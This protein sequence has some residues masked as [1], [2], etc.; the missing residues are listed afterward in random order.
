[1]PLGQ[2][3][4]WNSV[5]KHALLLLGSVLM[6]YPLLWMLS[7]SFKPEDIIFSEMGLWPRVVT[8][9]NYVKGWTAIGVPFSRLF[10]NS[11]IVSSLAVAGNVTSCA[12]AAY[13]FA[14]LNFK[15][16]NVW[17]M[18]MLVTMMLPLQVTL[19]PRYVMFFKAGWLNTFL[20]LT[21]PNFLAVD[22]FFIFLIV[23]FIRGL[24]H[25][26]D[27]AASIDG[28]SEFQTFLRVI[29]PLAAP[30]LAT[31]AI[32]TFIWSWDN[33]MS[34]LLYLSKV[35]LYTV[36]LGLRA[37]LDA[38]DKS[39]YGSLFAMSV[40]SLIP[41]FVIFVTAQKQLVEGVSTTGL[42]G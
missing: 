33:F 28:A 40:L 26:L 20:P 6:L 2:L 38:T 39:S 14:R 36:P 34:Q 29:I 27:D 22:S 12:L 35:T 11:F 25:D 9:D 8:F 37:F 16:K 15:F 18:L 30:A 31:T 7:S 42:K 32:F 19:V 24:P 5:T 3:L 13:A 10:L 4:H 41:A 23:Q 21:V 1:M 17:F